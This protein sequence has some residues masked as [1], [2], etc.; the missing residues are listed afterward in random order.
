MAAWLAP[1]GRWLLGRLPA[2]RLAIQL[3]NR[4]PTNARKPN[5]PRARTAQVDVTRVAL[6]RRAGLCHLPPHTRLNRI[7]STANLID[8]AGKT[9]VFP[10]QASV[11]RLLAD[12]AIAHHGRLGALIYIDGD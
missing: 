1:L 7:A 2:R 6:D 12:R 4:N 8:K 11:D 3:V 5:R 9:W 10:I